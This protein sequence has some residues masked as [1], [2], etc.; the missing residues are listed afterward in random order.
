LE[1]D[2]GTITCT[3]FTDANGKTYNNWIPAIKLFL[4]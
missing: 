4:W 2:G 1:V 3:K